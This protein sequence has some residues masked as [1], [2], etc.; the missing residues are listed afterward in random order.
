[1]CKLI[2][3]VA[4]VVAT[5]L[6][7][8]LPA[9]ASPR[10]PN[11][12]LAFARFN[13][14]I[15]DS[16]IFTVE[17]NGG[18][19][20]RLSDTALEGPR[21]SP[22]GSQI[23]ACCTDGGEAA[24]V[25]PHDGSYRVLPQADPALALYCGPW[26]RDGNRLACE[27][28]GQTDGTLNGIYSVRASDGRGLRRV[29]STPNGDDG[30]GDWAPD[31]NRLVFVRLATDALFVVNADG[32][33]LKQVTPGGFGLNFDA[34]WSPQ[35]NEIVFSRHAT[36]DARSS[37]WVVHS[38]GSGLRRIDVQPASTCGGFFSDP[39]SRGC[40]QPVWSP[41][42][43]RIAFARGANF[44]ADGQIYTINA[45][46]SG[47]LQVTTGPGDDSPDWGTQLSV[48]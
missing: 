45:D 20:R 43:K 7:I 33:G 26:S 27:G 8:T 6:L 30:P 11:G 37:L 22:D 40:I 19:V 23:A 35:G 41:D 32:T 34:N 31:G 29:T 9:G 38:D 28:F 48:R 25:N 12:Q 16:Q 15:G 24:I 10:D 46:G 18:S 42:G 5:T 21:W 2:G 1:M 44:D 36:S 47:L 13:T 17:P 3:L 4:T 39:N 14:T